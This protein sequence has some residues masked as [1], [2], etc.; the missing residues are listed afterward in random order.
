MIFCSKFLYPVKCAWFPALNPKLKAYI[1]VNSVPTHGKLKGK[2]KDAVTYLKNLS[3][4][5]CMIM[6]DIVHERDI[7]RT[8]ISY[9]MGISEM[10]PRDPKAMRE[11]L[12]IYEEV[13]SN[14]VKK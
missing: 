10:K 9:G 8:S 6:D 13:M 1:F 12:A 11:F 4:K 7:F 3:L 14:D 5:D 2:G